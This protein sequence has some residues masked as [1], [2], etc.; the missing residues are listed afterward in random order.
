MGLQQPMRIKP[1]HFLPLALVLILFVFYGYFE[2]SWSMA[3]KISALVGLALA[4]ITFLLGPLARFWPNV[5][6]RY[7]PQRKYLGLFAFALIVAHTAISISLYQLTIEK[8]FY[9]SPKTLGFY[10]ASVAFLIF[11]VMSATSTQK[12][13]DMLGY[14]TWKMVQMCG[15]LALVLSLAHFYILEDKPEKGGFVIRPLGYAVF[16]LGVVALAAKVIA[17]VRHRAKTAY[18]QHVKHDAAHE[19]A[20]SG[21]EEVLKEAGKADEGEYYPPNTGFGG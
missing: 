1:V 16:A 19:H 13:C 15:Y 7:I 5:F 6:A 14:R 21:R 12:A 2:V 4:S 3:N 20:V 11:L 8:I 17:V 9:E 18:E 10:A